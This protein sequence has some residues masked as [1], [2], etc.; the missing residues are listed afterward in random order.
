MKK[1]NAIGLNNPATIRENIVDTLT[2]LARKGAVKILEQALELEVQ[3]FI[4]KYQNSLAG[5]KLLIR[6]GYLPERTVQT[7]IGNLPVKV[8]RVRDKEGNIKFSSSIIPPYLKRSIT[9]EKLLPLLYLKGIS[10]GDFQEVLAPIFGDNAKNLSS[11]VISRLKAVWE[12]EYEQWFKRN[13]SNCKYVYWWVDGIYLSARM[14]DSTSCVLVIMG[15]TAE[16]KKELIAIEDGVRESKESWRNF[17]LSLK[18]RGLDIGAKLATGDGAMGFWAALREV[19]PQTKH[20]RCWCHKVCN[21]LDKLPKQQRAQAKAKL[22]EIWMAAD[23]KTAI[24]A[25]ELFVT[26]YKDKYPKAA[27]CLLKDQTELLEFYNFPAIHW[28]HIRTSNPIESTFATVRHRTERCKGAFSRTTI[29]TMVFKLC[30]NAEATWTR[31]RGFERLAEV[32]IGI[33]FT[34]GLTAAEFAKLN[35]D[36]NA[37]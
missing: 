36:R 27:D 37:A 3:E 2:D 18:S 11:S 4:N 24:K 15:L 20:Q 19:Y 21:I 5:Q 14:E 33:K 1:C 22:R 23:R 29:L 28:Q 7:G 13:L 9:I 31:V 26:T 30:K 8:P 12:Q 25:M 6:N 35:G 10:T 32:I 16:G 17:L 34:D